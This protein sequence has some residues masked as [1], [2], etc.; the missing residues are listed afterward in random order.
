MRSRS[1]QSISMCEANELFNWLWSN[2]IQYIYIFRVY[3]YI[4]IHQ[5]N[6]YMYIYICIFYIYL[7]FITYT[8]YVFIWFIYTYSFNI[9]LWGR[10]LLSTS[11]KN[12]S[13]AQAN[14]VGQA[15]SNSRNLR[16]CGLRKNMQCLQPPRGI[17][18]CLA[19]ATPHH[20]IGLYI[21]GV[22]GRS[23]MLC[24]T[25]WTTWCLSRLKSVVKQLGKVERNGTPMVATWV[26]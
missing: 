18:A 1:K 21:L 4:T 25:P 9:V 13:I 10:Q 23:P 6:L 11:L 19:Q 5:Y 7:S 26:E 22:F 24:L 3:L 20:H 2:N 17:F 15:A 12:P 14:H 16:P 8:L